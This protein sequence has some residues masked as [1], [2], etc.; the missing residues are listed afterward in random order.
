M[1]W[2]EPIKHLIYTREKWGSKQKLTPK[3]IYTIIFYLDK[4]FAEE[5]EKHLQGFNFY[6]Y[7]TFSSLARLYKVNRRTFVRLIRPIRN[8][9]YQTSIERRKLFPKEQRI[10]LNHLG[11]YMKNSE[12]PVE[13]E[14][15]VNKTEKNELKTEKKL[16]KPVQ[17]HEKDKKSWGFL[18]LFGI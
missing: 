2:L 8:E 10:I 15:K 1:Q 11:F 12:K 14:K 7:N 17:K 9:L 13:N 3:N 18:K 4:P 16:K 5:E 6:K